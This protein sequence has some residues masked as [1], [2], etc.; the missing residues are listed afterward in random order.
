MPS[1]VAHP[2]EA[3]GIDQPM[4]ALGGPPKLKNQ[5][6]ILDIRQSVVDFDLKEEIH[7]LLRPDEGPRRLPTLLL[8]DEKGLQLFEKVPPHWPS[9]WFGKSRP[10]ADTSLDNISR[11]VLLDQLGN[12]ASPALRQSHCRLHSFRVHVHRAGQRV[13]RHSP[14]TNPEPQQLIPREAI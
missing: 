12:P 4:K 14:E 9:P 7:S 6:D 3:L 13:R 10:A 11:G 1:L 2:V 8:Y 5:P